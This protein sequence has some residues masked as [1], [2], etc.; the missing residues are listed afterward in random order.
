MKEY[1]G[2]YIKTKKAHE[3][4]G[5]GNKMK[6]HFHITTVHKYHFFVFC[7]YLSCLY[8]CRVVMWKWYFILLPN[9]SCSCAFLVLIYGNI[10]L[11]VV[12][13]FSYSKILLQSLK[14]MVCEV[15]CI[16]PQCPI[17]L[18]YTYIDLYLE[19]RHLYLYLYQYNTTLT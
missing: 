5:F 19:Y 10:I 18:A 6:Y 8:L 2:I 3:Q 4:D 12:S 16:C 17:L 9:P 7:L 13:I 15:I 11:R 14:T 1:V